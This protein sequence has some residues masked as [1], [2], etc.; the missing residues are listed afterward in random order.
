MSM[1]QGWELIL[2]VLVVVLLF[3]ARKL[4]EAARGLGRSLRIFK[5]EVRDAAKDDADDIATDP[6]QPTPQVIAPPPP[7][8]PTTAPVVTT[9]PVTPP[10]QAPTNR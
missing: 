5:S 9:T 2:I 8:A 6:S 7:G 10:D 3:G 4:P 1:P